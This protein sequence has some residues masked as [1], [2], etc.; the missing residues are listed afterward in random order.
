M[1]IENM[2]YKTIILFYNE[3]HDLLFV[4]D[5]GEGY[6]DRFFTYKDEC[7]FV[8]ENEY[9]KH[10]ENDE[11]FILVIK[12]YYEDNKSSYYQKPCKIDKTIFRKKLLTEF[13]IDVDK[14]IDMDK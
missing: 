13:E 2:K 10:L 9:Y 3:D 4:E 7:W 6:T 14:I 12:Y 1:K 11:D 8:Y 5:G